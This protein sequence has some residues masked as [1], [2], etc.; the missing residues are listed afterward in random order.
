M[1]PL[2]VAQYLDAGH[3]LFDVVIFD[4]ASQIPTWD[5]VGAIARGKQLICVGDPKQLPPTNFFNAADSEGVI[6]EDDVEEMESILDECLSIGMMPSTL[7]WHYRSKSEGLIT[8]SNMQ[9]Y[10]NRLITFPSPVTQ[11]Q[12]VRFVAIDG[13]YDAGKSRTNRKEADAIVEAISEHYLSGKG[14][15]LS[16]GVITFNATQQGLIEKLMDAKR[17]ATPQLDIAISESPV[18]PFFIKNLENVQGDERD[19]I[20]FSITFGKDIN[21][22][23]SMNFG[24]MNKEEV[25]DVLML[26]HLVHVMRFVYSAACAPN[27]SIYL[28]QKHVELRT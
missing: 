2:S 9:Y 18:E 4:E 7:D 12:S 15:E 25:T 27:I 6:N 28:V 10:D 16:I 1:S 8:F 22:K 11:D 20:L 24:P 21:G 3:A 17:L 19:I 23:I 14:K 26:R 5:A 13:I